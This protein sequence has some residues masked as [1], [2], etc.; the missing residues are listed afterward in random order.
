MEKLSRF[1]PWMQSDIQFCR[2]NN[3]DLTYT[4]YSKFPSWG[5]LSARFR[6]LKASRSPILFSFISSNLSL[7]LFVC[8]AF[9]L[10]YSPFIMALTFMANLLHVQYL[11]QNTYIHRCR[12]M[13]YMWYEKISWD[14]ALSKFY[15]MKNV[16]G[17]HLFI[18]SHTPLVVVKFGTVLNVAS[19]MA[20]SRWHLHIEKDPTHFCLGEPMPFQISWQTYWLGLLSQLFPL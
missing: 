10:N 19:L 3:Y 6:P 13:Y 7:P 4:F 16:K 5:F 20:G 12:K 18:C 9:V 8:F 15:F 11:Y 17:A 14:W 2:L 1:G